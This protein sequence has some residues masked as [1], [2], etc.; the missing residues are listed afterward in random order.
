MAE[1]VLNVADIDE[2]GKEFDFPVRTAWLARVLQGTDVHEAPNA[3]EGR[4]QLRVHRQGP[5]VIV[6]GRVKASLEAECARCLEAAQVPVDTEI[7]SLMTARGENLRPEPDEV[8]LTPEELDREFFA[9]EEIVLDNVVREHLLLEVPIKPLCSE[10]CPG[11]PVPASVA[12]PKDLAS[13]ESGIDPRLAPLLKLV[14]K[15]DPTEE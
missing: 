8:E 11:I 10:D 7:T 15:L 13:D 5:D 12:G 1:F 6:R 14:G 3:P 4:V 2:A 9:G